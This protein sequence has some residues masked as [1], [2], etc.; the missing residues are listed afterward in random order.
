MPKPTPMTTDASARIQ[1]SGAKAGGTGG[2][3]SGSFSS[4]ASAASANNITSGTT[5]HQGGK[6]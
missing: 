3:Q 6:K 4:R 5:T 2:V 1:S